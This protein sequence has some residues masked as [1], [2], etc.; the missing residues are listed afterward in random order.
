M[1]FICTKVQF[2]LDTKENS[3]VDWMIAATK[4]VTILRRNL[5][6]E[7]R[8]LN[9]PA[10]LEVADIFSCASHAVREQYISSSEFR[11]D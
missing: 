9:I 6:Q 3:F 7:C 10:P 2:E 8:S 11:N 4:A 5:R 1:H